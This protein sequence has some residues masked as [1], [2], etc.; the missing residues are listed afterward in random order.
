M[1]KTS[2]VHLSSARDIAS[3]FSS[4]FFLAA[5]TRGDPSRIGRVKETYVRRQIRVNRRCGTN[6]DRRHTQVPVHAETVRSGGFG[7]PPVVNVTGAGAIT[8]CPSRNSQSNN[9]G[10]GAYARTMPAR[11]VF[12]VR[13]REVDLLRIASAACCLGAGHSPLVSAGPSGRRAAGGPRCGNGN[14]GRINR[15]P[16]TR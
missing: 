2:V 13:R 8:G 11:G 6:R 5:M 14:S 9:K 3:S 10:S 7:I 1:H 4:R 15:T 16:S 12:L